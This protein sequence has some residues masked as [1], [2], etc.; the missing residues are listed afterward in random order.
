MEEE[1]LIQEVTDVFVKYQELLDSDKKLTL[2]I[3]KEIL[4]EYNCFLM[5]VFKKLIEQGLFDPEV[6]EAPNSMFA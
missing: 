3:V 5:I 2:K 4:A 1:N 6:P